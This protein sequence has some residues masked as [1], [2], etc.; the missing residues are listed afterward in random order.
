MPPETNHQHYAADP[1]VLRVVEEVRRLN[2]ELRELRIHA[3]A[4]IEAELHVHNENLAANVHQLQQLY[5]Q[6]DFELHQRYHEQAFLDFDGPP[7]RSP[8]DN[9]KPALSGS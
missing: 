4:G 1:D 9:S 8:P 3:L 5:R 6:R 7:P 2:S